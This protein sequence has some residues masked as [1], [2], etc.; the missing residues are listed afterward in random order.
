MSAWPRV[1]RWLKCLGNLSFIRLLRSR[2][3]S[4]WGMGMASS[5]QSCIPGP[6]QWDGCGDTFGVEQIAGPGTITIT[7]YLSPSQVSRLWSTSDSGLVL[8][9]TWCA[10]WQKNSVRDGPL[11]KENLQARVL[12]V[13]SKHKE[14]GCKDQHSQEVT[15]FVQYPLFYIPS[16]LFEIIRAWPELL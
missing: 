15:K 9:V 16:P 5:Y 3:F 8:V 6:K 4:M 2:V 10:V 13:K 14:L 11:R 7:S 12:G 1:L